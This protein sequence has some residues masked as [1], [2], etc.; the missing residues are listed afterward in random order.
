MLSK[1]KSERARGQDAEREELA[2]AVAEQAPDFSAFGELEA[3]ASPATNAEKALVAAYW[4]Q[5]CQGQDTFTS[6]A[7]QKVLDHVGGRI[8]N[9]TDAI[10]DLKDQKPQL[11]IQL[12]KSGRSRQARKTYRITAPGISRVR[13]MIGNG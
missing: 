2:A 13:E 12:R 5:K 3:A 6:H 8:A 10:D 7:A 4:L 9:I 11:V 1:L